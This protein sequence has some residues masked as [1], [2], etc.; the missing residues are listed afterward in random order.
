MEEKV[1][2]IVW[3][4][5][6]CELVEVWFMLECKLFESLVIVVFVLVVVELLKVVGVVGLVPWEELVGAVTGEG[7]SAGVA[8]VVLV[9][10]LTVMERGRGFTLAPSAIISCH[11]IY[12]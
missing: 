8:D 6:E 4:M 5:L 9:A 11:D 10:K 7:A 1:L 12:L 3:L 2:V